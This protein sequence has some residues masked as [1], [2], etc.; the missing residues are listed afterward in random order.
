MLALL[1]P[2]LVGLLLIP[3][4]CYW[5]QD[6]VIDRIFSL[7]V[8]PLALT[9]VLALLNVPV[10]RV[11]PKWALN[12][13]EIAVVYAMLTIACAM[14]GEWMDM[15]A[16]ASYGFA[17]Y[18]ANNPRYGTYILPYV[19]DWFFFRDPAP[20]KAFG[21]GGKTF[22]FFVS[23]LPLWWPKIGAWTLLLTLVTTAMLCISA[24]LKDQ[25]VHKERLA[26]PLVQLP[27][28]LTEE[29]VPGQTPLW[30]NKLFWGSFAVVFAIDMLN[31]FSFLY[32]Q[33]PHFNIRFIGDFNRAFVS[34]PWNQTGWTPVG[35]F[36]YL[37][38]L[39]FLM[40][41]DLLFSLLV[42]FFVRKA[43]QIIAYSIGNEQGVFGGGGL[44]PSPP[45]FSEQSWGAFIGLFVSA[46]WLAR[47]HL[48]Q[49]W[50]QINSGERDPNGGLPARFLFG[51]L[52]VCI[53]GTAAIGVG[54]GLPLPFILLYVLLFLA[55]SVA[56]TRLRASLGAPTHEMAF[57]GPHQLVLDFHGSAGLS[58]ELLTRTLATFHFMNRIHRTHTMPSLMEGLYL[59]DRG[60]LSAK[61]MFLALFL[62]IP[63]G[64]VAG[65]LA[66]IYFG[67]RYTP[68][69]WVSG[70]LGGFISNILSTPRPPNPTAMLAVAG[71][72]TT[73]ML[74]DFLRFRIPGFWLH[75][76][77]YALA[78][79]FGVD[80][81]WFGLLI[82]LIVK[83]FVQRFYGLKGYGQL[84]QIAF[85]LIVG[86][87]MAELI[88]ATF[89]MLNDRQTT[90]SI[91]INGK[92]S[93]DQ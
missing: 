14:S 36:P 21:E 41:T 42:F 56:V 69:S 67:Y 91:S 33:L 43:Q 46:L 44:T 55:F 17:V 83:V 7:M 79:N 87:F 18:S 73:V 11:L 68:V 88:W 75:P 25:W 20:L 92:M 86:E 48:K 39:G 52:L 24:L 40:P 12:G 9:I 76:A 32:P 53:A 29:S 65:F 57:M 26:F 51:L 15:V 47:P 31:G 93:W 16:P 64:T 10:R 38:A 50:V 60:K 59:A 5:A 78:M 23:Q 35:I 4:C 62:A 89:S 28:A 61:G 66:H 70:E 82:V 85:G 1:R 49:L 58:N 2:L 63:L 84:R 71:G 54:I 30:K 81:Y 13:R 90:Y 22:G 37:S 77:G 74:L 72:F 45:Y 27:L 80:Y 34:P 3:V 6:Q 19:H 8:P